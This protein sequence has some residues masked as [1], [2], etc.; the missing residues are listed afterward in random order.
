M[1]SGY[2]SQ[3][4]IEIL[5]GILNSVLFSRWNDGCANCKLEHILR[6][7]YCV[8]QLISVRGLI[9]TQHTLK[10]LIFAFDYFAVN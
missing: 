1:N 9:I 5:L 8:K 3:L 6:M 7:S 10:Q 2:F 4:Y